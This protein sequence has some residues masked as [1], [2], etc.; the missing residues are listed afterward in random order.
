MTSVGSKNNDGSKVAFKSSV[1]VSETFDVE[2]V[3]LIDEEDTW[4]QFGNAMI[5]ILVN[6]LIDFKSQFFCDF[7]L[8]GSV[9][10]TH[11]GKEIVITLGS[12]IGNV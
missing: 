10:L 12:S 2:H 1:K 3:D 9:Y 5:D 8:L 6:Y 7:S 4:N 11:Q